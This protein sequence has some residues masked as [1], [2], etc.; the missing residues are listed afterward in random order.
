MIYV[1]DNHII[2]HGKNNPFGKPIITLEDIKIVLQENIMEFIKDSN[3]NP[4]DIDCP[5]ETPT[6]VSQ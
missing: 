3:N 5:C 2:V 6:P 1:N 4:G